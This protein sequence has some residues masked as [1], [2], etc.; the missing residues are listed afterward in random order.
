MW[1]RPLRTCADPLCVGGWALL[2]LPRASWICRITEPPRRVFL[3]KSTGS[4][5]SP[6]NLR[7]TFHTARAAW[8]DGDRAPSWNPA[9]RRAEPTASRLNQGEA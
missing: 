1:P 5:M 2:S 9:P 7:M 6:M 3:A 8:G 4:G